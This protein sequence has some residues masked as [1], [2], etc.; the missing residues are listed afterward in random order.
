MADFKPSIY[1]QKIFDFV[2]KGSGNAVINAVAGSGKTTT[3]VE[4]LKLI[5]KEQKVIFVAFNK[6]IVNELIAK[7][8]SNVEVKTMHSFGFG[9][10]RY[11]L[12]NVAVKDDKVMEII[13]SLYPAW[14]IPESVADGYMHRVRQLVDLARLNLASNMEELYEISEHH[15]VEILNGEIEKSWIVYEVARNFK[16]MIDMT[17]MIFLPAYYNFNCKKYDWVFVDECQDL[18]RCQQQILKNMVK[19]NGGRFVAVGDPRQAIYGFAGA[20]ARSFESLGKIPNTTILPLSVNYRC[21][22]SI[23]DLAKKIVPQ[24]EAFEKAAIKVINK[25][26]FFIFNINRILIF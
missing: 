16:K 3:I 22:S 9:A 5:P 23:I 10:V 13:K 18:N 2:V 26:N 15:G 19:P 11:A 1:Q 25:V 14:N 24:L 4:A 6:S 21:G 8:P 7:V 12:G 20:D 17:D